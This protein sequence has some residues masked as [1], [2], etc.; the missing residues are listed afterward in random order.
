MNL[1]RVIRVLVVVIICISTTSQA[2]QQDGRVG[3]HFGG[4]GTFDITESG[5]YRVKIRYLMPEI[6][7]SGIDH[8]E[9]SFFVAMIPGHHG[10]N[11]P[12]KP[13]LPVISKLLQVPDYEGFTIEYH[14]VKS[15]TIRP[16]SKGI[17]GKMFPSQPSGPKSRTQEKQRFMIDT[18]VY[19]LNSFTRTDT[20]LI[21]HT[22]KMRDANLATV[23]FIP[24]RYNPGRNRLEVITSA[25][26]I[27]T[28]RPASKSGAPG[29]PESGITDSSKGIKSFSPEQLING[30]TDKP[31]GMIIITDTSFRKQLEPLVRWKTQKGFRVTT[32]YRG[33][34]YAGT[35]F[36]QLR[37][38]VMKV[39]T[40][41]EE[42]QT[43]PDFLLIVGDRNRVPTAT[44]SFTNRLSDMYYGE[45]TGDG[46][47]I[48]EMFI[49]R[50]PSKDTT[51][52]KSVVDKILMYEK[53]EFADTSNF[54]L[55]TLITAGNDASY[56]TYMNGHLNYASTYYLNSGYGINGT[57][58]L[59]PRPDTAG[60]EVRRIINNGIGFMN[61]SGHGGTDRWILP[62]ILTSQNIDTLTNTDMYPFIIS[63]ACQTGNFAASANLATTFVVAPRKGA[64]G[65]IGCTGDSYWSEDFYYAVGVGPVT[66]N[67]EYDSD[68]LGF[69]DR[70]F[71]KN[72]EMPSQ[73]YYTMGQVNYAG[74]L[75]VSAS[76]SSRKKY[77][78]ETYSLL[79]DPSVIPVI[80]PQLPVEI[81]LPD[82]LPRGIR[83]LYLSAPP[84]TYAA[85]SDFDS[86]WDASHVSPS[87]YVT[88]D[89]PDNA[90]DSCQVVISGQGYKTFI[91]TLRFGDYSDSWLSVDDITINDDIIG[92]GDGK[93]DYDETFYLTMKIGNLGNKSSLDAWMKVTTESEWVTIL[94]DSV[95]IGE[96]PA[97]GSLETDKAFMM[98]LGDNIPDKSLISIKITAADA[99]TIMEYMHDIIVYAPDLTIVSLKFDDTVNGNG[100]LLP[101]RGESL[102]LIF[103]VRNSGSSKADG[104]F[105]IINTPD[106]LSYI[107]TSVTTGPIPPGESVEVRVP[108]IVSDYSPPGTLISI[109]SRIDCGFYSDDRIFEISI[110]QTRE[111][112][113]YG[114]FDIFPWINNSPVPWVVTGNY[115]YD[116]T[117]SAVSGA[118]THNGSTSL[119]INIDLPDAD[120][121]KFWYRVSSEANYDFF[122]FTIYSG[123]DTIR[124]RDSGEKEWAQYIV[125]LPPGP[126]MLE[127]SYT[128]DGNTTRGL[129]R[130]WIDLIDFPKNAFAIRDIELSGFVSPGSAEEYGDEYISVVVKNMG[131]GTIDG[132]NL[133]YRVNDYIS[134]SQYFPDVISYRDSVTATF[135][136]P[137]SL[138]KYGIYDIVVY[139]FNN[140]D[141][142]TYNDTIR[143][144]IENTVIRAESR[145]YP[146]PFTENLNL[147]INSSANDEVTV[148]VV[149]M[150]GRKHFTVLENLIEGSNTITLPLQGLSPGTYII[151]IKGNITDLKH[152]VLKL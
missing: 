136:K 148:T 126:H 117:K 147:F 70:L 73:W 82:T 116:Q 7:L 22:G 88:L 12:G 32:L 13:E 106:G 122:I 142:F 113:E 114:N 83:S 85:I 140:D 152:K 47:Y 67:P 28:F 84:F 9:G 52:V 11:D 130:A 15:T 105:L 123:S 132:F 98:K 120:T 55:N 134:Y 101:D 77:Y 137:V 115:A 38:T 145:A 40:A 118:I 92:N 94:S 62:T 124:F 129:D 78:W 4:T 14:N 86:L 37:D 65:F 90:G 102:D 16:G 53:Q 44:S 139:S 95:F 63:N 57:T 149:D 104:E 46:D 108:V 31:A 20:V 131:S 21:E 5:D 74:L 41:A 61:Y 146:N 27:V 112:F 110:G 87:G 54:W 29:S 144:S 8:A 138:S 33:D 135:N 127:W 56:T 18:E 69:Y 97:K 10:L 19:K 80:G 36:E 2:I 45:F 151:T 68:N 58:L 91:K 17:N 64:I 111:S 143:I 1:K 89:I 72:G 35:S 93:A 125:G 49:G 76:T 128:K 99:D 119:R 48:P 81:N 25:D 141:D 51:E 100:N 79:G 107:E 3:F 109:E 75:A 103:T 6:T 39:Y 96:I 150:T 43:P 34:N 59:S 30:Y 26:I 60:S 24:V 133:A 66:L 23:T 50:I 42:G 71:H 121:L